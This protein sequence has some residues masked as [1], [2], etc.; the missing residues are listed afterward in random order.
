MF[1]REPYIG[2]TE[3]TILKVISRKGAELGHII[4]H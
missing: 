2:S 4:K 3:A 1:S